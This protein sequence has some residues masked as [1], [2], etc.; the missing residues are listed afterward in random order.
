V[1]S[2]PGQVYAPFDCMCPYLT[3]QEWTDQ[4]GVGPCAPPPLDHF[5]F[6][7]VKTSKGADKFARFGPVLLSDALQSNAPCEITWPV[8]LGLPANKDGEGVRDAAT[9]REEY[10]VKP[11]KGVPAFGGLSDVHVVNQCSDLLIEV[12][13]PASLRERVGDE[14]P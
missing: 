6:Y 1:P 2:G 8:A 3:Q 5:T 10:R 7:N 14:R 13:K 9:H 4:G 11:V 12:G